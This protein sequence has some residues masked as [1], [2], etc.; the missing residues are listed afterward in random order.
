[1]KRI[2]VTLTEDQLRAVISALEMDSA[3]RI[4]GDGREEHQAFLQRIISKLAKAKS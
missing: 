1:M 2:T 3:F 4:Y